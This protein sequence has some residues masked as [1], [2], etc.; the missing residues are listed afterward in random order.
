[1]GN[2]P[3]RARATCGNPTLN[4]RD[5]TQTSRPPSVALPNG[6]M[7]A[8]RHNPFV[9][10]HSIVDTPACDTNVV[11]LNQLENDLKAI[12]TTANFTWITPGMCHGGHDTPCRNGEPGGLV[13][14]DAFLRKW[15]PLIKDSPAFKRDGLLVVTFDQGAPDDPVLSADGQKL[16]YVFRGESCCN[17][18][19]GPN[20]SYPITQSFPKALTGYPYDIETVIER[21]GGGRVGAVMLSPFIKPGTVS[22][23]P[24]NHY[25][26]LRTLQDLFKVGGY[27]GYS[28]QQGLKPIGNEVFNNR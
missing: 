8:A 12:D 22:D 5:R 3:T 11:N 16:T 23:V 19:P 18:Q 13:S 9:F 4:A 2:D 26:L 25:A 7:Y 10:F 14:A 15:V 21:S 17:Q 28:A 24:Y 27:L 20:V 1:L 6:D